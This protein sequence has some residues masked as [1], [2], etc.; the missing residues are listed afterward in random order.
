MVL[1]GYGGD[2]KI[3][4]IESMLFAVRCIDRMGRIEDG[5]I[6]L[7][8]DLEEIKRWILILMIVEFFE[9]WDCK[10]NI[11]DMLGYFDFVGEVCEVFYA[12]DFVVLVISVKIG[13]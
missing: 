6:I 1:F 7:D 9:W 3:I 8:F 13:V 2:G 4:F 12:V 11:F 10:I 5:I